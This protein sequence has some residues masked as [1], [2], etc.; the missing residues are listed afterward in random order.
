MAPG[1]GKYGKMEA[2]SKTIR[3]VLNCGL[4]VDRA[5]PELSGPDRVSK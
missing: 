1:R 5:R 4:F 2:I 3:K